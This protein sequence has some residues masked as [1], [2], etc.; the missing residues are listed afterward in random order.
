MTDLAELVLEGAGPMIEHYDK[1]YEPV[2]ERVKKI[3]NKIPGMKNRNGQ[4]VYEEE[5]TVE[6]D[7]YGS[8]GRG[9]QDR[10]R[11]QE[12]VDYN[13]YEPPQRSNTERRR[14]DYDTYDPPRRSNTDRPREHRRHKSRHRRG[15]RVVEE[16]YVY[17]RKGGRAKSAGRD[18]PYGGGG[19]GLQRDDRRESR[20]DELSLM[21]T[22]TDSF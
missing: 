13:T 2:K 14:D 22:G 3:P 17:E 1:V 12:V 10:P 18:G 9:V 4:D 8:Q 16:E 21:L 20:A 7:N 11:E 6:Y 19:R 15:D 5:D